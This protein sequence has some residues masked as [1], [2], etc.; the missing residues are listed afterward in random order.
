[1]YIVSIENKRNDHRLDLTL[2]LTES[3]LDR[4]LTADGF[5]QLS[6][7]KINAVD[8]TDGL[9]TLPDGLKQADIFELNHLLT[10]L[11][12]YD[13]YVLEDYSSAVSAFKITTPKGLVNLTFDLEAD[14]YVFCR[15]AGNHEEL[16]GW[17]MEDEG[18]F[19]SHWVEDN[20]DYEALGRDLDKYEYPAWTPQQSN[21]FSSRVQG[22]RLHRFPRRCPKRTVDRAR[23]E[24]TKCEG[25]HP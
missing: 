6:D 5:E 7:V 20:L 9:I 21:G 17:F 22:L 18:G 2:P 15:T 8:H 14:K 13:E 1:M 10:K 23:K 16:A 12:K 19:V 3:E 24:R 4:Q 11:E 25:Y